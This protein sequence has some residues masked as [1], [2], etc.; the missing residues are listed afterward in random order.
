MKNDVLVLKLP[1]DQKDRIIAAGIVRWVQEATHTQRDWPANPEDAVVRWCIRMLALLPMRIRW[2]I[3][4][5]AQK[6]IEDVL[7]EELYLTYGQGGHA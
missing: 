4:K 5:C 1:A 6:Q 7:Q 2:K 3:A